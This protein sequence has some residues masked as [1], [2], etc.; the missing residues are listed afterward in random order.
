[1]TWHNEPVAPDPDR[2][3]FACVVWIA[4]AVTVIGYAVGGVIAAVRW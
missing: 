2:R 1:M 3:F 4:L